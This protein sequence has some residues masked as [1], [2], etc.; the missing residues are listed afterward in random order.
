MINKKSFPNAISVILL[1][2]FFMSCNHR[3]DNDR[4]RLNF[5]KQSI[6]NSTQ[7]I[8]A[9][10]SRTYK[11]FESKRNDPEFK[12]QAERQVLHFKAIQ[13]ESVS[14]NK[15]VDS[16]ITISDRKETNISNLFT[17]KYVTEIFYENL[18]I[19]ERNVFAIDSNVR[20]IFA[21]N[22]VVFKFKDSITSPEIFFETCFKNMSPDEIAVSLAMIKNNLKFFE[23][24]VSTYF[25]NNIG[26]SIFIY[27][28]FSVIIGQSANIVKPGDSITI[29]SGVGAF[30]TKA[31]LH[32]TVSGKQYNADGNASATMKIKASLKPGKHIVPVTLNFLKYDSTKEIKTYNI[33]YTVAD[34]KNLK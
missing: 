33:E 15:Y 27:D 25:I 24:D 14:I 19:Y 1:M 11:E 21:K 5:L 30:T 6:Q 13:T 17:E 20:R 28:S 26:S 18:K 10:I 22:E 8:S 34:P 7:A 16:L 12:S 4:M 3:S 29:T 2:I 32:M 31:N 23:N 9:I